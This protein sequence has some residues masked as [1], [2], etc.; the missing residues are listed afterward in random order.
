[1]MNS[2]ARAY[3]EKNTYSYTIFAEE[4]PPDNETVAPFITDSIEGIFPFV[5]SRF[6][7]NI[8]VDIKFVVKKVRDIYLWEANKTDIMN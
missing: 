3:F 7:K 5:T 6:G 8:G 4:F 1:M 2:L